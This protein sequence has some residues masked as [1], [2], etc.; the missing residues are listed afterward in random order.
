MVFGVRRC[1]DLQ[2]HINPLLRCQACV[3][4]VIRR[5]RFGEALEDAE[6]G[7]LFDF[8]VA[9]ASFYRSRILE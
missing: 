6:P 4:L 7:S 1:D 2:K 3:E 9:H 8:G 5:V